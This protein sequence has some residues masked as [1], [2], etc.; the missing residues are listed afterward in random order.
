M[1]AA[2]ELAPI[3]ERNFRVLWIRNAMSPAG[4]ILVLPSFLIVLV[5]AVGSVGLTLGG[6][7]FATGA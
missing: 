4:F 3:S 1:F 2:S 6:L 7:I 5:P